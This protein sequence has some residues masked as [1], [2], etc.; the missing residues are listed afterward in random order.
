MISERLQSHKR[1]MP[2]NPDRYGCLICG[3]L[4]LQIQLISLRPFLMNINFPSNEVR[5][6]GLGPKPHKLKEEEKI[7]LYYLQYTVCGPELLNANIILLK[8]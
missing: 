1:R 6:G 3:I 4:P 2:W 7:S 5:T 8:A